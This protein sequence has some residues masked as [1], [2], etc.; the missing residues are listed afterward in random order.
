MM[1]ADF[2]SE[3]YPGLRPFRQ[4]ETD[5]FFGREQ[6]TD[7]LLK[8]LADHRFLAVTGLSGCGKSSLVRAGLIPALN[9]GFVA[10]AGC[11]WRVAEMRPGR[12]PFARLAAG[13]LTATALAPEREGIAGGAPFV[14]ETLRRG[15]MGLVEVLRQTPLPAGTNLLL[16]VDQFEEIFRFRT[17]DEAREG[18][19]ADARQREQQRRIDEADAFVQLLLATKEQTE[20][21][22][23]V[24]LTMRTDYL[25]HCAVF[26]G[27]LEVINES[28]YIPPPL[29][30][31]Q[32]IDAISAPARVF[33]GLVEET[34][35]YR[36]LNDAAAS[37]D[38]L[39][40]LQHALMRMWN[41]A[42][43]RHGNEEEPNHPISLTVGD[44][45]T[46]GSVRPLT[47]SDSAL[48]RHGREMLQKLRSDQQRHIAEMLFRALSGGT[49][50][51]R[52]TRRFVSVEEVAGIAQT[53][54]EGVIE[55]ANIFRAP[56]C[57]FIAAIAGEG[58]SGELLPET[59]LD[60]SHE[61]LIRHWDTLKQ[62]ADRE[63]RAGTEFRRLVGEEERYRAGQRAELTALE[64]E[65]ALVWQR[66]LSPSLEWAK[67][68]GGD[69]QRIER[70]LAES[71]QAAKR[72]RRKNLFQ[73]LSIFAFCALLVMG[74]LTAWALV[75]R[76]AAVDQGQ[77]AKAEADKAETNLKDAYIFKALLDWKAQKP[78]SSL[79]YLPKINA[80]GGSL[81]RNEEF[82]NALPPKVRWHH[83]VQLPGPSH[84]IALSRDQRWMATATTTGTVTLIDPLSSGPTYTIKASELLS[85]AS[86][87][88]GERP[89]SIQLAFHPDG[90]WLAVRADHSL[91]FWRYKQEAWVRMDPAEN[92]LIRLAS[93]DND[94][95]SFAISVDGST[96]ALIANESNA[97]LLKIYKQDGTALSFAMPSEPPRRPI[98]NFC[99]ALSPDSNQI[100]VVTRQGSLFIF[101]TQSKDT[102]ID[103]RDLK[104]SIESG[105]KVAPSVSYQFSAVAFH[106]DGHVLALG[107][108]DGRVSLWR[109]SEPADSGRLV[110]PAQ[111]YSVHA[112]SSP[113]QLERVNNSPERTPDTETSGKR[114]DISAC[115]PAS[116][117]V[118][119]VEFG[120]SGDYL[121]WIAEDNYL[122]F[123]FFDRNR[124]GFQI[125][126][127]PS[128]ESGP[129]MILVKAHNPPVAAFA[130]A[131]S[132]TYAVT[133]ACDGIG[134]FWE[135]ASEERLR[136]EVDC[137]LPPVRS[138]CVGN[139]V[140]V[141]GDDSSGGLR[142]WRGNQSVSTIL[143]RSGLRLLRNQRLSA[144]A[145]TSDGEILVFAGPREVLRVVDL[146]NERCYPEITLQLGY[147]F[148]DI[149]DIGEILAL[150]HQGKLELW[151]AK[152]AEHTPLATIDVE[153]D[154]LSFAHR[155]R[156]VVVTES[157][158]GKGIIWDYAD[159][160][161][162][163]KRCE[164]P[165]LETG[166]SN[167]TFSPD[168]SRLGWVSEGGVYV[169]ETERGHRL[170][171]FPS[172]PGKGKVT[173]ISFSPDCAHLALGTDDRDVGYWNFETAPVFNKSDQEDITALAFQ[174]DGTLLSG[175]SDAT[176]KMW[177]PDAG[178]L[179]ASGSLEGNDWRPIETDKATE[180]TG[181]TFDQESIQPKFSD[182]PQMLGQQPSSLR[183]DS[184]LAGFWR[185]AWTCLN[186]PDKPG[187]SEE[188]TMKD[189]KDWMNLH[190][191]A[192]IALL[193]SAAQIQEIVRKDFAYRHKQDGLS[194]L[195]ISDYEKALIEL[196]RAHEL[197][198][199]Q[200]ELLA[201]LGFAYLRN[202]STDRAEEIRKQLQ[203]S[204]SPSW[205]ARYSTALLNNQRDL[206]HLEL[207]GSFA[208]WLLPE[209]PSFQVSR[210]LVRLRAQRY[211]E[212]ITDFRE[213]LKLYEAKRPSTV[214]PLLWAHLALARAYR[215]KDDST[216][217]EAELQLCSKIT[218]IDKE[219]LS[220]CYRAVAEALLGNFQRARD[221]CSQALQADASD[222]SSQ[223]YD[224]IFLA[225]VEALEAQIEPVASE[226]R[227][228]KIS[229]AVQELQRASKKHFDLVEYLKQ[230]DDLRIVQTLSEDAEFAS[231][232]HV[233]QLRPVSVKGS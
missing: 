19:A 80:L 90:D 97:S 188:E 171:K 60:I 194:A 192:P 48:S 144:S 117:G 1:I 85:Q 205:V 155:H 187:S 145:W 179:I 49:A 102:L 34:L 26:R 148:Q 52:D 193:E 39:P 64:L 182:P 123:W 175:S 183:D 44:Y 15:P 133:V 58:P 202:G 229:A 180:W 29:S 200:K 55:V 137:L 76:K 139:V 232:F 122:N 228:H 94:V 73:K 24:L 36:M 74:G 178:R 134:R 62:W 51:R 105:D 37:Q 220:L 143:E 104:Q 177:K 11:R 7:Q 25:G 198:P 114:S 156:W 211:D 41:L 208:V 212:A 219:K 226:A 125:S 81:P 227:A 113:R 195:A 131:A 207:S 196:M 93:S 221:D 69:Y 106:P 38:Q 167:F 56:G 108:M 153:F 98:S 164:L 77:K 6:H 42:K 53:S 233:P 116:R 107:E 163:R 4:E 67:R 86:H 149:D 100:A 115:Y 146:L 27:L 88:P 72:E 126:K 96:L 65:N 230:F 158:T 121:V 138:I 201:F 89:V 124:K 61:S 83:L 152:G 31:D 150:R 170:S 101:D 199:D 18:L 33:N 151:D 217:A 169:W 222:N 159:L 9:R 82:A 47:K 10:E 135:M 79:A 30:R 165:Q 160:R 87:D 109:L 99:L 35:C 14:E 204:I 231:F 136:R 206:N 84:A 50:E 157:S 213:A 132:G 103:S 66:D 214:A 13:L 32:L 63:G 21:A 8:R 203:R 70:F 166:M 173:V 130:L 110:R 111:G 22:T 28:Q 118:K 154:Q 127:L 2:S 186:S 16:V 40:L 210:G 17:D 59:E 190:P 45:E 174:A 23:Y 129:E 68:Y 218:P 223:I 216:S 142:V 57:N 185:A 3:P 20:F 209:E 12:T 141:V 71:Q 120:P 176:I 215:A 168:D 172:Q 119:E 95:S 128:L 224:R 78:L 184:D 197:M 189:V 46:V 43:Q 162:P 147:E 54:P 92:R 191:H 181:L 91:T 112:P 225:C 140:T 75:E 161:D 5:I